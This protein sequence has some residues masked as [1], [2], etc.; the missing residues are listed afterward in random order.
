[1]IWLALFTAY[2]SACALW[3][4]TERRERQDIRDRLEAIRRRKS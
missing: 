4:L 3:A 1:M 2:C